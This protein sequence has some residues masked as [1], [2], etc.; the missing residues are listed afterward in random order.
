MPS[1][2]SSSVFNPPP[3]IPYIRPVQPNV[4]TDRAVLSNLAMQQDNSDILSNQPPVVSVRASKL[5]S[6]LRAA[7]QQGDGSLRNRVS[8]SGLRA[9]VYSHTESAENVDESYVQT[10]LRSV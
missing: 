5:S 8:T 7:S 2:S 1:T 9:D 6:D 3:V 10:D 4:A